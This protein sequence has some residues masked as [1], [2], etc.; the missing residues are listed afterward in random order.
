[1]VPRGEQKPRSRKAGCRTDQSL[2][3][4]VGLGDCVA[5]KAYICRVPSNSAQMLDDRRGLCSNRLAQLDATV[6]AMD[7]PCQDIA[8]SHV[9]LSSRSYIVSDELDIMRRALRDGQRA[10]TAWVNARPTPRS[11]VAGST[12]TGPIPTIDER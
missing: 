3:I 1:M 2:E 6:E 7:S 9:R 8:G 10:T 12:E 11:C 5:I 4:L